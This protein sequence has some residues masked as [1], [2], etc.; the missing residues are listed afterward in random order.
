[1]SRGTIFPRTW[2]SLRLI[3]MPMKSLLTFD[4]Q[5]VSSLR[6]SCNRQEHF[7]RPTLVCLTAI[8]GNDSRVEAE[9]ILLYAVEDGVY[10][11]NYSILLGKHR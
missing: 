10:D 5:V 8:V 11:L 4:R 9:P 2:G 6:G 7:I 1:M 3:Q